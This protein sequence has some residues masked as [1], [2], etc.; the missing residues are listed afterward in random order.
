MG[1]VYRIRDI[2]VDTKHPSIKGS[3]LQATLEVLAQF[4]HNIFINIPP[5][6]LRNVQYGGHVNNSL[7]LQWVFLEIGGGEIVLLRVH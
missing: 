5:R 7:A 4:L 6:F 1:I 2:A 3:Y